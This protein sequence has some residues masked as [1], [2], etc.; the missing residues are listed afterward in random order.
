MPKPLYDTKIMP[1]FA[2]SKFK[3][4]Y[5]SRNHIA[6]FSFQAEKLCGGEEGRCCSTK[7]PSYQRTAPRGVS[8]NDPK[9][10]AL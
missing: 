2:T 9:A 6:V 5:D 1:I 4:R 8:D 10:F 3:V 7:K